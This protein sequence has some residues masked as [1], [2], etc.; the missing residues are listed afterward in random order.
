MYALFF[1]YRADIKQYIGLPSPPAVFKIY[2]SCIRELTR[3]RCTTLFLSVHV[4]VVHCRCVCMFTNANP[5]LN[6]IKFLATIQ[7]GIITPSQQILDYRALEV[8]RFVENEAT[9]VSLKLWEIARLAQ[10]QRLPH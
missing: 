10:A 1:L 7:V 4:Y 8:M 3:V 5:G 9:S 2:H 6:C